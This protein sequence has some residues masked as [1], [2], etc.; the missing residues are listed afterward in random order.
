M[1]CAPGRG[2]RS[3]IKNS[4]NSSNLNDNKGEN[5]SMLKA[6]MIGVVLSILSSAQPTALLIERNCATSQP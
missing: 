5:D 3:I 6:M 4:Q 2:K 1:V